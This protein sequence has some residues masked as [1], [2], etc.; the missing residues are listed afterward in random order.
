[1]HESPSPPPPPLLH[2]DIDVDDHNKAMIDLTSCTSSLVML[3]AMAEWF[4]PA[5]ALLNPCSHTFDPTAYCT[6]GEGMD[7]W[8]TRRKKAISAIDLKLGGYDSVLGHHFSSIN[9]LLSLRQHVFLLCYIVSPGIF[10]FFPCQHI[11]GLNVM[12]QSH[13]CLGLL[14]HLI[15]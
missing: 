10:P 15:S 13:L 8:E 7:G 12:S 1:M 5:K 6:K 3:F 9:A 14:V 4:V 2:D 11:Q